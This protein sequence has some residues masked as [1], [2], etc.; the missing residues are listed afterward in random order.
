M[1]NPPVQVICSNQPMQTVV[2]NRSPSSNIISAAEVKREAPD[3]FE[4]SSSSRSSQ[5]QTANFESGS[6]QLTMQNNGS[7]LSQGITVKREIN[8]EE[9]HGI[10]DNVQTSPAT[11]STSGTDQTPRSQSSNSTSQ[12]LFST[13]SALDTVPCNARIAHETLRSPAASSTAQME[14]GRDGYAG[15][16]RPISQPCSV[17]HSSQ[18]AAYLVPPVIMLP[19]TLP[20]YFVPVSQ[21]FQVPSSSRDTYM[22]R[23]TGISYPFNISVNITIC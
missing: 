19:Q 6:R 5:Q 11:A 18:S 23:V 16:Y 12:I 8:N 1:S 14:P 15:Y 4:C 2:Q 21:Q 9:S 17:P 10:W 20:Q 7:P 13:S 22:V 3:S